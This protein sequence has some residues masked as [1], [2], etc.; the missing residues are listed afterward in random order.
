[1]APS[2]QGNVGKNDVL[3]PYFKWGIY[4]PGEKGF[5]VDHAAYRRTIERTRR[6]P[7]RK[8]LFER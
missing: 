1:M 7:I 8:H 6:S 4:K 5:R 3:E 2:W